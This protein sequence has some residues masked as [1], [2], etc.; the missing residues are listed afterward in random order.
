MDTLSATGR[1][2]HLPGE[3]RVL[4]V[5]A[6]PVGQT[7]AL[8]LARHGIPVTVL[9]ARRARDTTGSRSLCQQR[10][11]LDVWSWCGAGAIVR[12]GLTWTRTRT[13]YRDV[14]LA[15]VETRDPGASPLPAFVNISQA[16]TEAVL[17]ALLA[18]SPL[19]DVRWGYEVEALQEGPDG[20]TAVA[21]TARG[22]QRVTGRYAVAC[23]GARG[24]TVRGSLG[25]S[26]PGRTYEDTFL[27][28]DVRTH[29]PGWEEERRFYFD[30]SWNR[31]RQVLINP[32]PGSVLRIDWQVD[33]EV[34]LAQEQQ[35]G[36]LHRRISQVVGGRPYELAWASL[37][38]FHARVA[39]RFRVGRVFLAGDL[40][41]Q[42][43]PFGARGL[44]AGVADVD[45]LA[46]KLAAVLQGWAP[47]RL[48]DSYEHERTGAARE[49]AIVTAATMDFL[50]PRSEA[51]RARRRAV[52]ERAVHDPRARRQVDSGR[53]YESF[54]YVDSPLTTPDPGRP[55]PGRPTVP[56]CPAPVPGVIVPDSEVVGPS[57]PPDTGVGAGPVRLR[58]LVRG[59]VS[60]LTADPDRAAAALRALRGALPP[61]TPVGAVDLSGLEGARAVQE[62]LEW[63][64]GDLWLVR[65]DAHLVARTSSVEG[66][67]AAAR[68]LL[69][70]DEPLDR[71]GPSGVAPGPPGG[72]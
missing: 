54:W 30:P 35:E 47:P 10:D 24:R 39:S 34:D 52:L 36:S 33:R 38:R 5:G 58:D 32:C 67:V 65:P 28:A 42:F 18:A 11:V 4:V 60:V 26:F 41:H 12:E 16:R 37:Y 49:N 8:L 23:A 48:L 7:A 2:D 13:F 43:S 56:G 17:D 57:L 45:N 9:E 44:N 1:E 6:G 66:L 53:L 29:L 15:A 61:R 71:R 62:A 21:R 70:L 55:W 64:R 22:T 19:V 46:W 27:V 25:V 31:G 20:V 69:C 50:I 59:R 40:A 72:P 68:T 63:E 3:D 14:E 51:D